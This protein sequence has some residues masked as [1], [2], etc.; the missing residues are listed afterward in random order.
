MKKVKKADK[1]AITGNYKNYIHYHG[2]AESTFKG[3]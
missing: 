2:P 1:K 3:R